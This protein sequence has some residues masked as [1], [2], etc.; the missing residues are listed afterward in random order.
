MY[1]FVPKS[2]TD[3]RRRFQTL[4][5][6]FLP[7]LNAAAVSIIALA[8]VQL[9]EKVIPYKLT[10]ILVFLS[11]AARMLSLVSPSVDA[12]CVASPPYDLGL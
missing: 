9:P 10:R 12:Q 6:R 11:G 2:L 1:D 3:R 4:R 8:G 5:I 7:G